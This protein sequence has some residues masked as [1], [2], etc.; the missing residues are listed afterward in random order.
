MRLNEE[1]F[2]FPRLQLLGTAWKTYV[3]TPP[4]PSLAY[5]FSHPAL[6]QS[7][8]LGFHTPTCFI[9]QAGQAQT[10]IQAHTNT[11]STALIPHTDSHSLHILHSPFSF[12]SW[13]CRSIAQTLFVCT[14]F[15]SFHLR[16]SGNLSPVNPCPTDNQPTSSNQSALSY[17]CSDPAMVG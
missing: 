1:K 2:R 4:L 7:A 6:L 12:A 3:A 17:Y 8:S 15:A 14:D 10:Q 16:F 5:L 9:G 11:R 13:H